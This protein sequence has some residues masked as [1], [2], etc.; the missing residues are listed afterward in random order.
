MKLAAVHFCKLPMPWWVMMTDAIAND[1]TTLFPELMRQREL[2]PL[3]EQVRE[4]LRGEM[5][6]QGLM[7]ALGAVP[8]DLQYCELREDTLAQ[9]HS[10]Y[11]EWRDA[12]GKLLGSLIVHAGGEF[13]AEYDVLI[14]H[15][16]DRRWFVEAVTAW[17]RPGV[18]KSEL[19][20]LA[21]L[22]A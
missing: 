8:A 3:I 12:K 9:T 20:L 21:A 2:Q 1:E 15:P 4:A 6:R 19:R 14:G 10:F 16:T 18:I 7:Q 22:P 17:G 11:G 5:A 13:F